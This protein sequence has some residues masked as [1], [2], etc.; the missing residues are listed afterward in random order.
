MTLMEML[1]CLITFLAFIVSLLT[2]YNAYK[3]RS[4]ILAVSTFAFG[5][6]MLCLAAAFFIIIL[7]VWIFS[8]VAE[9]V[10]N[11]LF[12]AGFILLGFGSFK[13]YKMSQI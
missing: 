2:L 8:S 5:A 4:G 7:P 3:L 9:I 10:R 11:V 12:F 13:I 1:N 6:G